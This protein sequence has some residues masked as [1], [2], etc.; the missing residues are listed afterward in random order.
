MQA[1]M[2]TIGR[3]VA[4]A[5]ALLGALA[6]KKTV[7]MK[8][9]TAEEHKEACAMEGGDYQQVETSAG[10]ILTSFCATDDGATVDCNWVARVCDVTTPKRQSTGM[11]VDRTTVE[12]AGV[13]AAPEPTATPKANRDAAPAKPGIVKTSK[14]G[15]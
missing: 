6:E 1:T 12:G 15:R 5:V 8:S 2:R 9:V 3:L 14:T 7:K 10:V 4:I 11:N 13:D